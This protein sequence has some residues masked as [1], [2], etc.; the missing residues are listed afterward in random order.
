MPPTVVTTKVSDCRPIVVIR[1]ALYAGP[2]RRS[3]GLEGEP[4]SPG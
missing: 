1:R 3:H 2:L 4:A